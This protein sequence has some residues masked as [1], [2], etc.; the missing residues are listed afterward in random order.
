MGRRGH[1]YFGVDE[2]GTN[3]MIIAA[4]YSTDRKDAQYSRGKIGKRRSRSHLSGEPEHD[5]WYMRVASDGRSIDEDVRVQAICQLVAESG[6]TDRDYL[7][8]DAF[9]YGKRIAEKVRVGLSHYGIHVNG[10]LTVDHDA[11]RRYPIV[12]T[13][14]FAAYFIA[15]KNGNNP[16]TNREIPFDAEDG[17]YLRAYKIAQPS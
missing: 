14:D 2:S 3:P 8:I 7:I 1:K 16:Y 15:R 9:S 13:A 17:E 6:F 4:A 12:N 10:N 5:F 11:D